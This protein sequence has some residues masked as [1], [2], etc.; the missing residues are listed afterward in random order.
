VHDP[1]LARSIGEEAR[2]SVRRRFLLPR[3]LLDDLRLFKELA[4]GATNTREAA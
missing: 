4:A 3:L 1:Q 2:R